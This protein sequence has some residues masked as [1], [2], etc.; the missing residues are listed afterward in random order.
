MTALTCS[1]CR[2]D[3]RKDEHLELNGWFYHTFRLVNTKAGEDQ[4]K[5]YDIVSHTLVC[6]ILLAG[7]PSGLLAQ[8]GLLSPGDSLR[9]TAS[10]YF[11]Y[12]VTGRYQ[13]ITEDTLQFHLGGRSLTIPLQD[14]RHLEISSGWRR[15][16]GCGALIGSIAGDIGL[17]V[18]SAIAV[19]EDQSTY[20][21]PTPVG[22]SVGGG[23][24]GAIGGAAVG[25]LVGSRFKRVHWREIEF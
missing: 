21:V 1:H 25:A 19:S 24:I 23:V 11:I 6:T 9:V 13:T 17:G 14:I 12:P 3:S 2:G 4:L 8:T 18:V 5:S 10:G 20:T 7:S 15:Q 22:A 16:T